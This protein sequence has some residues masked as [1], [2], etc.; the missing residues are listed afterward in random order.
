MTQYIPRI[1]IFSGASQ[2]THD[3]SIR[4]REAP[5]LI[6]VTFM[7]KIDKIFHEATNDPDVFLA[8]LI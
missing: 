2:T 8:H 7:Q 6:A 4:K 3:S 1:P 5:P